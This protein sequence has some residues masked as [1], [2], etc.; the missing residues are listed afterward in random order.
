MEF[1]LCQIVIQ[2]DSKIVLVNH[3]IYISRH[4]IGQKFYVNTY[5]SQYEKGKKLVK[6]DQNQDIFIFFN[7]SNVS[8]SESFN[9]SFC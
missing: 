7:S 3:S 5:K 8:Y 1:D 2:N 4:V 6:N 9:V